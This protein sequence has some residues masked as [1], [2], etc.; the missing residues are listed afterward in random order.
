MWDSPNAEQ[1]ATHSIV[2]LLKHHGAEVAIVKVALVVDGAIKLRGIVPDG[3]PDLVGKQRCRATLLVDV[4][5]EGGYR[6]TLGTSRWVNPLPPALM[7]A[8]CWYVKKRVDI[9]Y[10]ASVVASASPSSGTC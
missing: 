6:P 1:K 5:I 4:L 9:N 3:V 10:M 2:R 8:L 7:T